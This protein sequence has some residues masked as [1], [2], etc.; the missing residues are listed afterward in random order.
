MSEKLLS[1]KV[2]I[3]SV[4]TRNRICVPPM[5]CFNWTDDTGIVTDKHIKHY[6]EMSEGG[7][8]L[9]IVEATAVTKRARLHETNIGIWEDKQIDGLSRITDAIH[10]YDTPCF[11]QLLHAGINGIDLEGET[12]SDYIVDRGEYVMHGHE[13]SL[14]RIEAT[15]EDFVNAAIRAQKAGF[16]GIELHGCHSYLF[17]QFMSSI[18]NKR[19]DIYGIEKHKFAYDVMAAIKQV[20]GSSFV[21]GIR[22]ASFEPTL[23]DGLEHAKALSG[24]AEFMDMSYGFYKDMKAIKPEGFPYKEGIY[25]AGEIKKALPDMPVFGVDS[26]TDAQMAQGAIDLTNIDM[27][28]V[29]RGFLVN[30]SFGNCALNGMPTGKCLHCSPA[31]YWS[32]HLMKNGEPKCAGKILF[33][34]RK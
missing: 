33:E 27:V 17:S 6:G 18:V 5:V 13:M 4:T 23:E 21:V 31:C 34:R 15:T 22:L 7:A 14:D 12:A 10:K 28:D 26:I 1:D 25:G 29:G 3:S 11:I 16:D 9:I 32:P 19:T 8:G 20:C 30:P 24:V 2:Q